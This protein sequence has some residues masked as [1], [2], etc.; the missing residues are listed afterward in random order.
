MGKNQTLLKS[1]DLNQDFEVLKNYIQKKDLMTKSNGK[2]A[3][4][5]MEKYLAVS[6]FSIIRANGFDPKKALERLD[7]LF[8]KMNEKESEFGLPIFGKLSDLNPFGMSRQDLDVAIDVVIPE[9]RYRL[10]SKMVVSIFKKMQLGL[11][12]SDHHWTNR[13]YWYDFSYS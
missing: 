9:K 12:K 6:P 2:W 11:S 8:T 3:R 5:L 4:P 7:F 10:D 1:G 13:Q